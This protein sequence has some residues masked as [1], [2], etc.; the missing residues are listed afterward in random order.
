MR[1]VTMTRRQ[2][3]GVVIAVAAVQLP[4]VVRD[5]Y[6]LQVASA[7]GISAILAMSLQ[8]LY[9]YTGQMS[10]AH[11]AFYGTGAYT[12]VI[13]HV[14]LEV[15]F[16]V[17]VVAAMLMGGLVALIVG[18]PTLRLHG[19]YLAIASL[20]LQLGMVEFLVQASELTGGTVGIFG[21]ARPTIAGVSLEGN[22]SYYQLIA[23]CG[24]VVY[25][26]CGL[27]VSSRF[28]RTLVAVR[29]D[30]TAA[31]VLGIRASLAKTTVFAL[32]AMIASL[33]GALY[34]YQIKFISPVSFD[35]DTSIQVL[36]MV[37]IG[38]VASLPGAV[39]GAIAVTLVEQLLFSAGELQFLLY[40][41]W[42]AAT[43]I[44]LPGG[45]VSL[46]RQIRQWT[47]RRSNASGE[48]TSARA[49]ST[50]LAKEAGR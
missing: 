24:V 17:S 34:A 43:L 41:A 31:G 25:L 2:I 42:V 48:A 47:Q 39:I 13:L 26:L 12:S 28:G 37:V 22:A 7:I 21:I 30:E 19:H 36:A 18:I 23:G 38:G 5:A 9:G 40:G 15:S 32:S 6:F 50:R 10:F 46:P 44:F 35:L 11:A 1:R 49:E 20:A 4:L 3:L 14:R 8:L 27:V 29:E 16:I 45:L 33:A